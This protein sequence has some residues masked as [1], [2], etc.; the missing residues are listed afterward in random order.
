MFTSLKPMAT[1]VVFGFSVT[2]LSPSLQISLTLTNIPLPLKLILGMLPQ[3]ALESML[4]LTR[5]YAPTFGTISL[6]SIIPLPALGCS[7]VILTKP[8]FL[9]INEEV[10]LITLEPPSLPTSWIIV[11]CLTLQPL[12]LVATLGTVTTMVVVSSQKSLTKP[13]LI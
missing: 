1:L 7:L 12:V 9:G 2:P 8:S 13:F 11:I 4:A 10:F 3:L 5:P 6:I